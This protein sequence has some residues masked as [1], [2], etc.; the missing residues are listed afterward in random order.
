MKNYILSGTSHAVSQQ[1]KIY[2][3]TYTPL[4]NVHPDV[5]VFFITVDSFFTALSINVVST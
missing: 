2:F 3:K 5:A 4:I 1:I